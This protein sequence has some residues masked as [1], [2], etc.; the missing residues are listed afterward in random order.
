MDKIITDEINTLLFHGLTVSD[1]LMT[2]DRAL[3]SGQ[4][5]E[6]TPQKDGGMEL[7][8]VQRKKLKI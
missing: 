7:R 8:T 1:F 2:I 3:N 5:I 4:R 6:I